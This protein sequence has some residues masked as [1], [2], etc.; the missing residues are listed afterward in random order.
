MTAL[1]FLR[2]HE[3]GQEYVDQDKLV[4]FILD[5]MENGLA[6]RKSSLRMIETHAMCP[7]RIIR[8]EKAVVLDAGGTNFRSC[9]V[10]FDSEGKPEISS[11]CRTAMPGAE[12]EVSA[13]EFYSAFA[14]GI[15]RF[16]G[17][18]DRVGFCFSYA[19]EITEDH[20]GYPIVFSKEI[21]VPGVAG[22]PLG[23]N[24]LSVLSSRGMD[25]SD[26]RISVLNDTTATLLA[27]ASEGK[28][29]AA[30][31]IGFILGTGTNTAYIEKN[32][33]IGKNSLSEGEQIVN[34]ESGSL[35]IELTDLD[36]E[37]LDTTQDPESYRL[38]KM[39]SGAYIGAFCRS[40]LSS[41]SE[42]GV[43]S[44]EFSGKL[45][46]IEKL[47]TADCAQYLSC[48]GKNGILS[49]LVST[50]SDS[51][52]LYTILK[53]IVVRSAKLTAANLTAAA[54]RSSAATAPERPV[55]INADGTTFR[56]LPFL[57]DYTR[58]FLDSFLEKERG[59]YYRI[60]NIGSSPVIGA[61]VS[62]LSI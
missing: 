13:N 43:F 7:D 48:P 56:H 41:A 52:S 1:E 54:V 40:V 28:T 38:E 25:V 50:S 11:F 19:A 10:S 2:K 27:A 16:Y 22:K 31:Y 5:E 29:D 35:F 60:V 30:S 8:N 36:S 33:R 15:G 53:G 18:T 44:S 59:I 3:L 4:S 39:I 49:S 55:V 57:E 23:K 47:T 32:E 26:M 51:S 46:R 9:L 58:F 21:K 12:R 61:A 45:E 17:E 62:A 37:F 6:G 42:S 34:T 20:E 14:D 24:I